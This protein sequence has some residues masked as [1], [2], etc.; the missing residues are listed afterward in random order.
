MLQNI[1]QLMRQSL[2]KKIRE[3]I[4]YLYKKR[5][6]KAF[7]SKLCRISYIVR[8]YIKL[9]S[10]LIQSEKFC[11]AEKYDYAILPFPCYL[12]QHDY[13]FA[14]LEQFELIKNISILLFPKPL[15]YRIPQI[16]PV[17]DSC[18]LVYSQ[19]PWLLLWN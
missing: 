18:R 5:I 19:R 8:L 17:R 4:C 9:S 3:L 13:L 15:P 1:R 16:I 2:S 6:S 11:R 7:L 10:L 12:N 14:F